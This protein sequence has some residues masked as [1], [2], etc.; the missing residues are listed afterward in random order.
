VKITP[1]TSRKARKRQ[2][3]PLDLIRLVVLA[4][5]LLYA[6]TSLSAQ[7]LPG[8]IRGYKVHTAK[9]FVA[10][11]GASPAKGANHEAVVFLGTPSLTSV[12]F[13]GVQMQIPVEVR[14]SKVTGEIEFVTFHDLKVDGSAIQ[15]DEIRPALKLPKNAKFPIRQLVNVNISGSGIL[16]AGVKSASGAGKL[17][18]IS[19]TAFVFGTFDKLGMKFKRVIP[20]KISA[21]VPNPLLK[22]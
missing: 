19:G 20:V 7:S 13:S 10:P 15:I 6:G 22:S 1:A 5:V 14:S 2:H 12:G 4:S 8:S 3:L 16:K 18:S 17:I 21:S 9:I 11:T